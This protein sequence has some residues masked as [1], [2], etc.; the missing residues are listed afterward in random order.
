MILT[1]E[2]SVIIPVF[3]PGKYINQI[4]DSFANQTFKN[5]E[6]IVVDDDHSKEFCDLKI[7][8]EA[9]SVDLKLKVVFLKTAFRSSSSCGQKSW[10]RYCFS[11]KDNIL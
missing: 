1:P 4:C 7:R 11:P 9:L 10:F 8:L 5:Y 3:N 6:I 2:I